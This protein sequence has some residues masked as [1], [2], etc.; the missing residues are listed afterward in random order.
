M[1]ME[2]PELKKLVLNKMR[3]MNLWEK[4]SD[5]NEVDTGSIA[6]LYFLNFTGQALD[7][8]SV[9]NNSEATTDSIGFKIKIEK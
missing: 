7:A 6:G 1:N 9:F 5:P 3:E 4:L 2:E 8:D